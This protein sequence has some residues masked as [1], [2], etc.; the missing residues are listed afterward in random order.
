MSGEK[1]SEIEVEDRTTLFE[2]WREASRERAQRE[3]VRQ[4]ERTDREQARRREEQAALEAQ[5]AREREALERARDQWAA[6]AKEF[7]SLRARAEELRRNLVGI[8]LPSE[9]ALAEVDRNDTGAILQSL[10]GIESTIAR[11]RRSLNDSMLRYSHERADD[12]GLDD[13]LA[14]YQS[15]V[16]PAPHAATGFA[17]NELLAG[18]EARADELRRSAFKRARTLMERVESRVVRV[19]EDLGAALEAVLNAPS[20]PELRTAETRLEVMVEQELERVDAEDARRARELEALQTDRVAALMAASLAQMGYV[21]SNVYESAYTKDG[22]IFACRQDR[23][24]AGHAVRLTIDRETQQVTS[25]VVRIVD[26]DDPSVRTH[27]RETQEQDRKADALWCDQD[28]IVRFER[29]LADQG[30]KVEFGPNGDGQ[31]HTVTAAEVAEASPTLAEHLR[32]ARRRE[33]IAQQPQARSRQG[34]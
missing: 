23:T 28:G 24:A 15:F 18:H 33:D 31:V 10:P 27:E 8:E 21:V 4:R 1:C 29:K 19:S 25:N 34:T 5:R 14:W 9:P 3:A 13:V 2:A 11:Y 30:V 26:P 16:A 6:L 12:R 17:N 32:T 7:E 22:Q 20:L